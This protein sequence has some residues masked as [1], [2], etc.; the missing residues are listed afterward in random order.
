MVDRLSRGLNTLFT[1]ILISFWIILLLTVLS[2]LLILQVSKDTDSSLNEPGMA[3]L[4]R[5]AARIQRSYEAPTPLREQFPRHSAGRKK[6]AERIYLVGSDGAILNIEDVPRQNKR[7][8]QFMLDNESPDAPKIRFGNN[9]VIIGPALITI[10]NSPVRLYLEQRIDSLP[11]ELRSPWNLNYWLRSQPQLLLALLGLISFVASMLLAWHISRPLKQLQAAANQL[12]MGDLTT[13]LPDINRGDEVGQLAVSLGQMVTHLQSAITNQR[14][15][16]SDISHELR[17]PLTRLNMA[18]GLSNKRYGQTKENSR[19]ERESLRLEEMISA[20]LSLSRMQLDESQREAV[21]LDAL[22]HELCG[23]CQFEAEQLGKIFTCTNQA[24]ITLNCYPQPLQSA[25]EN[26]C[27]NALKYAQKNVLLQTQVDRDQLE[28]R[29]SDDGPGINDQELEHI[30]R[31]FYRAD[32]ARDRESGGVGLG[33]AI[34]D[35]AVRQHGGSITANNG[36]EHGLIV[37]IRLPL[38]P[39][40]QGA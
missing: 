25:I 11:P 35:W 12:A 40:S 9:Q 8:R 22:I 18:V 23:D 21:K 39:T 20:L 3:D 14:R 17:S 16:L 19:I 29:V 26:V 30:F 37:T 1:K 7:I 31:P 28:I 38:T 27:R 24:K 15:L 10:N 6:P 34:A 4:A 33:L 36:E 5:V 2:A 13:Q 32:T